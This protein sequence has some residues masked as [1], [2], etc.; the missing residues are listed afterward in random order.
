MN[1]WFY[2]NLDIAELWKLTFAK[3]IITN[4]FII[5]PT[6]TFKHQMSKNWNSSYMWTC[7]FMIYL[8][9]LQK[10]LKTVTF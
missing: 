3:H 2:D 7:D 9:L 4:L 6:V 1:L 5:A 8:S 10:D